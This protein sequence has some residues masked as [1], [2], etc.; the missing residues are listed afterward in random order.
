MSLFFSSDGRSFHTNGADE[1][2]CADRNHLR[3][4]LSNK[5]LKPDKFCPK[6]YDQYMDYCGSSGDVAV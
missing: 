6:N 3:H 5:T 2:K 4:N 1:W